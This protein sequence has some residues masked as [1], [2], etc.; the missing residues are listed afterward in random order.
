MAVKHRSLAGLEGLDGLR[1]DGVLLFF[2]SGLVIRQEFGL[3]ILEVMLVECKR[4]VGLERDELGDEC[5]RGLGALVHVVLDKDP[6]GGQL[7]A[8]MRIKKRTL[9][10]APARPGQTTRSDE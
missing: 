6:G 4:T 1:K 5:L 8:A 3:V 10:V 9:H 2:A 7:S